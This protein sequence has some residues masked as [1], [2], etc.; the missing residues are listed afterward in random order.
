MRM[1]TDTPRLYVTS[2]TVLLL[3]SP[4][5]TRVVIFEAYQARI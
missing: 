2:C 3:L 4:S 1:P 5:A